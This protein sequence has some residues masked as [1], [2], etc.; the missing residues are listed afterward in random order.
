[1]TPTAT[2][3]PFWLYF[4]QGSTW[5]QLE[6]VTPGVDIGISRPSSSYTALD[7]TVRVQVAA[8]EN[9]TWALAFTYE[10]AEAGR[11]LDRAC[12]PFTGAVY[13]LDQTAMQSNGL[14]PRK[15]EGTLSTAV[16]IVE[17]GV[18]FKAFQAG[19]SFTSKVRNGVAYHL[20]YTTR[21]TAG[22]TIGTY[23]IGAGSA[24]NIVAPSGTGD[25]RGSVSF[26]P[27]S[28]ADVVVTWT[29]ADKTSAAQFTES[30]LQ[31]KWVEG[32][33]PTPCRV[34]VSKGSKTARMTF[35]DSPAWFDTAYTL[36][37]VG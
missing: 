20:A 8:R 34:F 37:E 21:A 16:L 5:V 12:K 23:K 17:D 11:W 9:R 1:M 13:L 29:V 2:R 7:G 10:D 32:L 4:E 22:S 28:N 3:S 33:G 14:D 6:G 18:S 19:D 24:V 26:V 25:R 36:Q 27:S 31:S 30:A 15:T 35:P